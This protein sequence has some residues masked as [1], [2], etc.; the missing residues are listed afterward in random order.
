[1][2]I[3]LPGSRAIAIAISAALLIGLPLTA[4]AADAAHGSRKLELKRGVGTTGKRSVRV[5][6]VQHALQRHGFRVH[7]ADGRF[8]RR[9]RDA[10]Q[11]FQRREGLR[12]DGI[13]G[14][15]TR[16]ALSLTARFT[17]VPQRRKAAHHARHHSAPT[18]RAV[19]APPRR[20]VPDPPA[21]PAPKTTVTP[22]AVA[23][24]PPAEERAV[25]TG[26]LVAGALLTALAGV[27]WL[28]GRPARTPRDHHATIPALAFAGAASLMDAIP[29][30][31]DPAPAEPTAAQPATA[32]R[33]AAPAAE[34]E[35][36]E[37]EPPAAEAEPEP[38]PEPAAAEP[39]PAEPVPAGPLD[40]GDPVIAYVDISAG[41]GGRAAKKIERTC[42]RAGWQL[43]EVVAERGERRTAQRAGLAYALERIE[44]GEA[45]ALVVR[46]VQHLGRR[47]VARRACTRRL[48]LAGA[49]LVT[50]IPG[51]EPLVDQ[52]AQ[53][54]V[55]RRRR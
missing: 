15:Q 38:E 41:V 11:R 33:T 54:I 32:D 16:R 13:V 34:P 27:L 4:P 30:A 48:R 18:P 50:C 3:R 43:L 51:S 10:V 7:G 37:P 21:A 46:D 2:T 36:A 44:R 12:V 23:P 19:V 14:P 6:A 29:V 42:A 28:L 45:K 31:R 17:R 1:M 49:A 35:P 9:T 24:A 52:R 20:L 40:A 53:R 25:P 8:G 47:S 5:R 55:E 22:A 39:I 26:W